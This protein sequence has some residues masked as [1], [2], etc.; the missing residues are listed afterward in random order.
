MQLFKCIEN[1][2][3]NFFYHVHYLPTGMCDA[4][5]FPVDQL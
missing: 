4:R 5:V 2:Y 1:T 3:I